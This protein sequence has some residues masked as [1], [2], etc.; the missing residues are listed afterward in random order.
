MSDLK[1]IFKKV[2]GFSVIKN[3]IR[4]RVIGTAIGELFLLGTSKKAL[5]ILRLSTQLKIK[6]KLKKKYDYVLEK[7]DKDLYVNLERRRS[8]KVWV[9]W[10]QGMDNAPYI[11]KKC[12]KSLQENLIDK[13]IIV[14]TSDNFEDYVQFPQYIIKKWK[15]GIITNTHFSDLLRLELLIKYGGTWIDSTVLCT[16]GNIPKY[17]LDSDLFFYQILKPGRDGHAITISS[18]LLTACTNNKVL[19]ITRELLYEYWRNETSLKDYFLFHIFMDIVLERYPEEYKKV[20]K[21]CNSIPHI[22]LLDLFNEFN[23]EF[24]EEL[25]K[26]TN[27]HKLTYKLDESL[28]EKENTYYD[29]IIKKEYI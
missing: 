7:C 11:V 21:M 28:K 29:V 5:E 10:L 4:A 14:I 2:N 25:K 24:Y 20:I 8:N 13:N 22:L 19:L 12:Y 1:K 3:Y 6:N 18:W 26:L 17:I 16:G 27:F 15:A 23:K 9:C